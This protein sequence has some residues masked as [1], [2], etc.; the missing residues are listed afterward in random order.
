MR[1]MAAS[2]INLDHNATTPLAP[3]VAEAMAAAERDFP[4]NPASQHQ[5]GRAAR[6][7]LEQIRERIGAILGLHL[8]DRTAAADRLIFTSGATEANNL[9][10]RGL[11]G[12]EPATILVS[13]IEHPSVLLAAEALAEAGHQIE[14]IPVDGAGRVQLAALEKLLTDRAD[15]L[16]V[17]PPIRLVSVMLGNHETG[18]L[19]P[20]RDI[21]TLCTAHGIPLHTDASQAVGKIP[22]DFRDLGAGAM[23]LSAH[24]FHGPRGIGAVLLRQDIPLSPLLFGGPQQQ[25]LRPGTESLA[26]PAGMLA[27]LEAAEED[28]TATERM[29]Q[30]RNDFEGEITAAAPEVTVIGQDADRLPHVSCLAFEPLDRQALFLALDLAGVVCSTGSACESGSSE[31]SPVLAEMGCRPGQINSALR[32]SLGRLTQAQEMAQAASRILPIYKD[33][34]ERS[35]GSKTAVPATR[36]GHKTL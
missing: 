21:A 5:L 29:A 7:Q 18:V 20:I 16:T 35:E 23:T 11:A 4:G 31:P 36:G 19:Q 33:L 25:G 14:R 8:V 1:E 10:L 26:L 27:A 6:S 13:A 3:T 24:K 2:P 32:F 30:L 9:V 22:V 15:G 12:N 34:R 17:G 28:T